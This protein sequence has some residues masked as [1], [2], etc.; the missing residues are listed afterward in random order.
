MATL[1]MEMD[2]VLPANLNLHDLLDILSKSGKEPKTV[3]A[4]S[5]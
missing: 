2:A 3:S 4:L 1:S 5:V